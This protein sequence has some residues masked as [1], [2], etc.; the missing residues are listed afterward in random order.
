MVVL[1]GHVGCGFDAV[2]RRSAAAERRAHDGD[3]HVVH[4]H[5][6]WTRTRDGGAGLTIAWDEAEV[7]RAALSCR[8]QCRAVAGDVACRA[9]NA[10]WVEKSIDERRDR[11]RKDLLHVAHR[12]RAINSKEYVDLVH[13]HRASPGRQRPWRDT[14]NDRVRAA[15]HDNRRDAYPRETPSP[16][17]Q[18]CSPSRPRRATRT[19]LSF[20]E[21]VDSA[22]MIN[23]TASTK[24]ART[25]TATE[26]TLSAVLSTGR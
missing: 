13:R 24:G 14:C 2:V 4:G 7:V 11:G 22:M 15:R 25:L 8:S 23:P 21:D 17:H 19:S 12:R 5:E 10:P 3:V 20:T 1:V 18:K 9:R 26:A 16:G 6:L